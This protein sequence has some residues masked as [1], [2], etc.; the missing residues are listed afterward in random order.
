MSV[1]RLLWA[2][3]YF[4]VLYA[5]LRGRAAELVAVSTRDGWFPWHFVMLTP[6]GHALHF[7]AELPH[8]QNHFAPWWFLGR[9]RGVRRGQ[10]CE[11]LNESG[12]ELR[13]RMRSRWMIHA[14][15][16]CVTAVCLIPWLLA[17]FFWPAVWMVAGARHALARRQVAVRRQVAL[18]RSGTF[19]AVQSGP[20]SPKWPRPPRPAPRPA[21]NYL[22]LQPHLAGEGL[23]SHD[24][25]AWGAERA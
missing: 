5:A 25:P 1:P 3:C 9:V 18:S 4:L 22:P 16:A 20:T 14:L 11:A 19:T 12:R 15:L 23:G 2:N 24:V 17:W 6:S 8:H 7:S 21:A 10:L 13:W